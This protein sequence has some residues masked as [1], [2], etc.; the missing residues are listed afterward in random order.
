ME[1]N[2]PRVNQA[3]IAR[4]LGISQ[5]TVSIAL[6]GDIRVSKKTLSLIQRKADE[7]GYVPDPSLLALSRYRRHVKDTQVA[8]GLAWVTNH[9][10]EDGWRSE[11]IEA[12]RKGASER[13]RKL[14]YHLYDFWM[15]D[16]SV[17]A[18]RFRQILIARGIRGLLFAPQAA[19]HTEIEFDFTGFAGVKFG[20]S[21]QSPNLHMV[22]NYQHQTVRLAYRSLEAL[23]YRKIGF[24]M[25]DA[26]DRRVDRNFSGGYH[27]LNPSGLDP[28][29]IQPFI[30][31]RFSDHGFDE[32]YS[33]WKPDAVLI[34]GRTSDELRE[35]MVKRDLVP[36]RDLAFAELNVTS[37]SRDVAGI[38]QQSETI[39]S[40]A[41]N[42][43]DS[44]LSHFEYGI[45]ADP[46]NT[47]IGGVWRDGKSAPGKPSKQSA[48]SG[49]PRKKQNA[50]VS[51][52]KRGR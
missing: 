3:D 50:P 40:A 22:S 28:N 12:Y 19:Y 1:S 41:V 49:A 26:V 51:K 36:G 13:A 44:L 25:S 14:G 37:E 35:W 2:A 43:L 21:L 45:P 6:K 20:Y 18:E 4:A 10:T 30:F 16:P 46:I 48:K 5:S 38:D 9:S 52:R 42:V 7:M 8:T 11:M 47:L 15:A 34:T 39:G 29:F 32:W 33:R 24:L 27:S 31:N 17:S 23:G